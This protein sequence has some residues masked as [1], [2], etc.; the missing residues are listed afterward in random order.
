MLIRGA[1]FS[2]TGCPLDRGGRR[3]FERPS[4]LGR[5]AFPL[6]PQSEH[7]HDENGGGE[8]PAV[9]GWSNGGAAE[10]F[11]PGGQLAELRQVRGESDQF[12]YRRL[13][14]PELAVLERNMCGIDPTLNSA[15]PDAFFKSPVA[16]C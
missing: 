6:T 3:R 2:Q 14:I 12:V 1:R 16:C 5:R 8:P 9:P 11:E 10:L 7:H 4:A 13:R 15:T